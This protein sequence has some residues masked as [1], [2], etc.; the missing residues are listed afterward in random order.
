MAYSARELDGWTRRYRGQWFQFS[1]V[2]LPKIGVDGCMIYLMTKCPC[3]ADPSMDSEFKDEIYI[4]LYILFVKN[5]IYEVEELK[6]Y[7]FYLHF[8]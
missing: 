1:G 7:I 3:V 2:Q 6:Y 8:K 4:I 5:I